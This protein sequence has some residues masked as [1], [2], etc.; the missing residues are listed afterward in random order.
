VD[1]TAFEVGLNQKNATHIPS[2][3]DQTGSAG[4]HLPKHDSKRLAPLLRFNGRPNRGTNE[5]H[6]GIYD[7]TRAGGAENP[8]RGQRDSYLGALL[9]TLEVKAEEC[10]LGNSL[11]IGALRHRKVGAIHLRS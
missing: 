6:F 7:R 11:A 2:T 9:S 8:H 10:R 4:G 5:V 1:G 3:D